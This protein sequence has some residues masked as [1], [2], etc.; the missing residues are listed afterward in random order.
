M[1]VMGDSATVEGVL[2]YE[3][4]EVNEH[5]LHRTSIEPC[6]IIIKGQAVMEARLLERGK[7]SGRSDDNIETIKKRFR[8]YIES[9]V[10]VINYYDKQ[11]Q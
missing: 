7:T 1:Q 9:T 4:P 3:C 2:F 5:N 10:P 6:A 11:V 8:T